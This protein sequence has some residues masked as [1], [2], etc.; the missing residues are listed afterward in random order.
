MTAA[1]AFVTTSNLADEQTIAP[2]EL[3]REFTLMCLEWANDDNVAANEL[4]Q[5]VLNCVNDELSSDGYRAISSIK[6]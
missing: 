1:L 3:I 2:Q 6:L 5:Y 4:N